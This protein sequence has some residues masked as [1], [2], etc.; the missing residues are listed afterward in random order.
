MYPVLALVLLVAMYA[1]LLAVIV[2]I[3]LALGMMAYDVIESRRAAPCEEPEARRRVTVERGTAR[4]FV[5]AGG[6]FWSIASLGGLYSFR[7]TGGLDVFL[8]AVFPLIA[9]LATLVIGWYY[10]RI[11]A[12]L[13]VLA[14]VVVV[15]WGGIYQFSP[16]AWLLVALALILPALTSAALFWLARVDQDAYERTTEI[17]LE[18]SPMFAARSSLARASVAA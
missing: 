4:A 16:G 8:G 9:C 2:L 5:I 14:S 3:P 12:V 11:T 7:Q 1:A 18:L 15:A 6:V 10:E 13:L 17:R